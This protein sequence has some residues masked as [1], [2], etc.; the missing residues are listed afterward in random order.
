VILEVPRLGIWPDIPSSLHLTQFNSE[1]C[2]DARV[3]H[4]K[5]TA[6]WAKKRPAPKKWTRSGPG[7]GQMQ[8]LAMAA[9]AVASAATMASTTTVGPSTTAAMESATAAAVAATRRAWRGVGT[10]GAAIRARS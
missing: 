7:V 10:R 3:G 1:S 6:L 8:T 2:S 9:T 4:E 5:N